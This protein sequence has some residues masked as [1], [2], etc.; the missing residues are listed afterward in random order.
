MLVALNLLQQATTSLFCHQ[1]YT[2][3]SYRR[4][5]LSS[6]CGSTSFSSAFLLCHKKVGHDMS[7]LIMKTPTSMFP[8]RCLNDIKRYFLQS[9]LPPVLFYRTSQD[10]YWSTDQ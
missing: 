10:M 4:H 1:Q 3:H 5:S 9:Q 6:Q 7:Y 8:V 2:F